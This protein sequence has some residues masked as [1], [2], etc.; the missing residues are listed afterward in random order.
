MNIKL[1]MISR[2]KRRSKMI[3]TRNCRTWLAFVPVILAL[4]LLA[5]CV[6]KTANLWGDPKT[7]LILQYR[8][9]ENQVLK[10]Q[11]SSG[12]TMDMEVMGQAMEI[13]ADETLAFTVKSKGLKENNYHLQVTIDSISMKITTPQGDLV[14]DLSPVE[15]KSFDMIFSPI[16][17]EKDLSSAES[18][19]YE[20]EPGTI[21]NIASKFQAVFPDFAGRPL[22]IGDTWTT[23]T[24]I[25]ENSNKSESLIML[26]LLNTLEGFETVDGME[27]VRIKAEFTGTVEGKSEPEPGVELDL[28]G[29]IKGTDIWY[30]AYKEGIFIKTVS[31]GTADVTATAS[32]QGVTIPMKRKFSGEMVLLK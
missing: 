3:H 5:G 16:G 30:F 11:G 2:K 26:E 8:M 6:A 21:T 15:G 9:P 1:T 28:E 14:P 23:R 19:E 24:A 27:C 13:E 10:Y 25:T 31:N 32:A 22:K 18:I 20:V 17:E 12:M 7:G 4:A 29:E